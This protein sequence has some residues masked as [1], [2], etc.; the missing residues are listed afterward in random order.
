MLRFFKDFI[1][2]LKMTVHAV[3]FIVKHKFYWFMLIP[4]VLMLLIY[5]LGS[6]IMEHQFTTQAEN[7]NDIIWYLLFLLVEI[8]I[9]VLLMKFSKYLVITILSPL[10]SEI[11]MRTEKILVGRT[12]PFSWRQLYHDIRRAYRIIIRNLMWE[13]AFFIIIFLVSYVGWKNP[14]TAPV[15]YLTFVIGFFYYGFGFLDYILE[16]LRKD[17]DESIIFVR[18]HRGLATAIGAVY[19]VLI[20]MPVDIGALF[21]WSQMYESPSDFFGRFFFHLFLWMCASA[22]P[23]LAIVT[24]TLSMHELVDL[25][26][27]PYSI[28]VAEK[29]KIS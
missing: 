22:A 1:F 8:S 7:M 14:T 13:Y 25:G 5:Y 26:K 6:L 21:N 15:F 18:Q 20:L 4:A 28:K 24:A 29:A 17:I 2:G 27:N 12:Y 16:R 9:A 19:S 3:R 23:I 10:I 11:S